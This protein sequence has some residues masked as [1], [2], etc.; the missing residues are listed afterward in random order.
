VSLTLSSAKGK[1]GACCRN[2]E[3][4]EGSGEPA[5]RG[6]GFLNDGFYKRGCQEKTLFPIPRKV[7]SDIQPS[8]R[9]QGLGPERRSDFPEHL[10]CV[11][12][13]GIFAPASSGLAIANHGSI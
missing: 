2:P 6:C 3:R 8:L 10:G 11:V 4:S 7:F 5:L 9:W 1:V 13:C 12:P